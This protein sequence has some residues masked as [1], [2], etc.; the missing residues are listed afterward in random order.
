MWPLGPP[1]ET[2]A[3]FSQKPNANRNVGDCPRRDS[4][5]VLSCK[6]FAFIAFPKM[7]KARQNTQTRVEGSPRRAIPLLPNLSRR[8]QYRCTLSA[9][10]ARL[11]DRHHESF[12]RFF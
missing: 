7:S 12:R 6:E 5:V 8:D 9:G 4:S 2:S 1:K 10:T 11:R 3:S